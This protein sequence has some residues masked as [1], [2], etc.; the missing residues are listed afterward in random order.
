M[1]PRGRPTKPD[2]QKASPKRAA[3]LDADLV[4]ML[5]EVAEAEKKTVAQLV[6]ESPLPQWLKAK[7]LEALK[8]RLKETGDLRRQVA[9][10]EAELKKGK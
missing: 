7:R 6:N 5:V 8:A 2:D 4:V 9:E 3:M 1:A 10:M